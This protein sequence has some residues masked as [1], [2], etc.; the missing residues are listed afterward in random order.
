MC[1]PFLCGG[2]DDHGRSGRHGRALPYEDPS[3]SPVKQPISAPAY[4]GHAAGRSHETSSGAFPV[5]YVGDGR[6][7]GAAHPETNYKEYLPAGGH[8][9]GP[10]A[11]SRPAEGMMRQAPAPQSALGAGEDDVPTATNYQLDRGSDHGGEDDRKYRTKSR[12]PMI[13]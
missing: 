3:A 1:L 6:I 7:E 10:V 9:H 4:H 12:V 5:S 11:A 8:H 2:R 13:R